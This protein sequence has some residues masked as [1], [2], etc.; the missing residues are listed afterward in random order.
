MRIGTDNLSVFCYGWEQGWQIIDLR[1]GVAIPFTERMIGADDELNVVWERGESR[2]IN[3]LGYSWDYR[4]RAVVWPHGIKII[5]ARPR[6][7][8][9][10]C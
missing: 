8:R 2:T 6:R 9:E 10:R 4:I 5:K 3:G 1:Y 7:P